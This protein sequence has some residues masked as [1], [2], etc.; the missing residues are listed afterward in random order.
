MRKIGENFEHCFVKMFYLE[1]M[2]NS[3]ENIAFKTNS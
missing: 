2:T 1:K 3:K